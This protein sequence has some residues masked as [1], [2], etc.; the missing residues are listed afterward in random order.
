MIV[1][2]EEAIVFNENVLNFDKIKLLFLFIIFFGMNVFIKS[3]LLFF[4][5]NDFK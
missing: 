4:D 2:I 1:I 5:S 3:T